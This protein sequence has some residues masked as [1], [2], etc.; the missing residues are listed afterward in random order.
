VQGSPGTVTA[1][2][3][4]ERLARDQNPVVR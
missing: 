4:I 1:A 2:G 3:L